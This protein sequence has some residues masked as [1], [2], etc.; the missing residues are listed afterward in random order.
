MKVLKNILIFSLFVISCQNSNYSDKNQII[1]FDLK[2]LTKITNIKLSD[3]KFDDIEYIPLE[4]NEHCLFQ[5]IYDL[6]VGNDFFLIDAFDRILEFKTDGSFVTKIGTKGRGPDEYLVAHDVD[7]DE[8]TQNIYLVSGWQKKFFVYSKS[9]E[10][11]RTFQSPQNTTNFKVTEDGILCY[12]INSFANIDNSYNLIDTVGRIIKK[13]PNKYPWENVKPEIFVY[14]HEN[15]FYRFNNRLFKKEIYSDTVFVF[16]NMNFKPYFLI[17]QGKRTVTAKARSD[18]SLEYLKDNYITPMNLFE[19]GDYIYYEFIVSLNGSNGLSFIGSKMNDFQ[20]LINSKQGLT[21]DL[22]GGPSIWPKTIK[23]NNAIICWV[24]AFQ[25]KAHVASE[26]FK[27]STPKYPEK[28]KE[29]EKL[30]N[31]LKETDNPVLILVKLK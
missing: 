1:T 7:I 27:N 18:F 17:E 29:L 5:G 28:K 3:L 19:F 23:D 25:L 26:A 9:G 10:L 2:E 30:A 11:I 8:K 22:D 4:T 6:K 31:R 13:I 16:E 24:D 12:S 20:A 14:L 21:N 15:L